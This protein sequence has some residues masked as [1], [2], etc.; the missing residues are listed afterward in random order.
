MTHGGGAVCEC[1]ADHRPAPLDG[2]WHHIWP[3]GMGGPDVVS[4]RVFLCPTAHT[5]VHAILRLMVGAAR[6]WAWDEVVGHFDAPVSR[7]AYAVAV[8]GFRR[9]VAAG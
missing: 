4:N 7:Y 6:E 1:R 5:N 2:E 9:W 3:L 8:E